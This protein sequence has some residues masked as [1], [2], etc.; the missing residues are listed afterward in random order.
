[1]N[2]LKVIEDVGTPCYVY[3]AKN[4]REQYQ[5]LMT[6]LPHG[7]TQLFY[8]MKAL[9]NQ[10]I[11]KLMRELGT[12]IDTVS[13]FEIQMALQAGFTPDL[14]IFTPNMVDFSEIEAA[15]DL[16]VGI[17]IENLTN[18]EKFG[19]RIGARIPCCIR[20]NPHI[21]LEGTAEKSLGWYERSKFGI[22]YSQLDTILEITT[23]CNIR[24]E[25]LHIHSSHVI[26]GDDILLKSAQLML[27]AARKFP[28]LK[29]L[30]FGG[31]LNPKPRRHK[32]TDIQ[33]VGN[34]L[35][36]VLVEFEKETGRN[37]KLRFEPGRFLVSGAGTLYVKVMVLKKNKDVIFAG[38]DSGFNHL[39]R[40]MLYGA[41]HEIVNISNPDSK[42]IEYNIVGNLCEVDDF[43][44]QY[45]VSEIREGDILA[46][47]DTG[48]YGYSMSSQY[49]ARPR[50]PEILINAG[51]PVLIR[52]R[53]EYEDLMRTQVEIEL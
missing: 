34:Q 16:G 19:R 17:N 4:I 38:V 46:I 29:F 24:V 52:R 21:A 39:I 43:A 14:I 5:E 32:A 45:S 31:G 25:G 37:I 28:E 20:F 35:E 42:K 3:D 15:V 18:L 23:R 27:A 44:I 47:K 49:N 26:M 1:M 22:E 53:E 30:D 13:P 40:P 2:I 7:K 48:S 9:S 36:G 50:P 33:A 11:L 12:G 10:R 41:Q 8:A 51:P 6:S